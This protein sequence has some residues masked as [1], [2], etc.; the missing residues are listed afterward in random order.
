MEGMD[1]RFSAYMAAWSLAC[2]AA[3]V[4][5]LRERPS[6]ALFSRRYWRFLL[7]PW[8]LGTFLVAASGMCIM[9]PYT[10]DPTW[11]YVDAGFMALLTFLS[12][13]WAVG[14]LFKAARRELPV[15]LGFAAACVWLFSASWS[16]DLYILLKDGIYPPSWASNMALSSV[17]YC[18]AGLMWSLDWREGRGIHFAFT[19]DDW[20]APPLRRVFVKVIWWALP[21]MLLAAA[22]IL[23]FLWMRL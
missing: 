4:I 17:L 12:A 11:D 1:I 5:L 18:S 14:T 7:A 22:L 13:P 15:S 3:V 20:P 6:A 21:W 10:G 2:L 23:P 16:Y 9:A 8:K 19:T